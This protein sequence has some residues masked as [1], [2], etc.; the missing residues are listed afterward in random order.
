MNPTRWGA[1]QVIAPADVARVGAAL[2]EGEHEAHAHDQ[3]V[4]EL[5]HTWTTDGARLRLTS[6]GTLPAPGGDR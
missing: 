4:E 3:G 2:Y 1:T 6:V 5:T